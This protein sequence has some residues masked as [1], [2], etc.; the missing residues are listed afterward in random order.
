MRPMRRTPRGSD[1]RWVERERAPHYREQMKQQGADDGLFQKEDG[2][3]RNIDVDG[4]YDVPDVN[5][6]LGIE[7][8]EVQRGQP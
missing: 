3:P 5:W 1:W 7:L 6:E 4:A 8:D 2:T